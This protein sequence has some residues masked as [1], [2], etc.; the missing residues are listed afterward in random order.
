MEKFK[1][2]EK[3]FLHFFLRPKIRKNRHGR[4]LL[5]IIKHMHSKSRIR[6]LNET[7]PAYRPTDPIVGIW[8]EPASHMTPGCS[9]TSLGFSGEIEHRRNV[10]VWHVDPGFDL[11]IEVP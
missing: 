9:N 11:L 6:D 10:C 1:F 7:E 8:G 2:M 3:Q 5:Q 4:R